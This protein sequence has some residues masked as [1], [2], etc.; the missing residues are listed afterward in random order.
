MFRK[1][2]REVKRV[3]A[4]AGFIFLDKTDMAYAL[5]LFKEGRST[6]EVADRVLLS[7]YCLDRSYDA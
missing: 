1:V 4:Q 3:C 7:C 5:S 2:W 6:H